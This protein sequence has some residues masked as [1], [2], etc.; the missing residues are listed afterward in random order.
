[1][2]GMVLETGA[3]PLGQEADTKVRAPFRPSVHTGR[4]LSSQASIPS[5]SYD[6]SPSM[7]GDTSAA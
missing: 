7:A 5:T 1:M 4:D 2:R 3:A 6:A